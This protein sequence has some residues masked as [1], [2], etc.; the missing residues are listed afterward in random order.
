MPLSFFALVPLCLVLERRRTFLLGWWHGL[1]FWATSMVWILG[2]LTT[3][4]QLAGWLAGISLLLL[5]LWLGIYTALFA[6]IG[7]PLWRSGG[8]RAL[9]G[10]PALWVVLEVARGV[11]FTGFPWNLAAHS[12]LRLPGAL[13]LSAWIGAWGVSFLVLFVNLALARAWVEKR[14]EIGALALLLVATL[15]AA[16]GRWGSGEPE[17]VGEARQRTAVVVQPNTQNQ[18]S[19]DSRRFEIAYARLLELSNGACEPGRLLLWPES[20]AWPL[21]YDRDPRLA[22]DIARLNARGCSVLFNSTS[23]EGSRYFNS[24]LLADEASRIQRYD[25]RHLVPFGEYVPLAGVFTFIKSIARNAG[26]FSPASEL[27]LLDWKGE[28]LGPALCYEVVFPGE[29]AEVVRAGAT[30]LVTATNDAWYG[31]SA[32]PWQHLAAARFR[33]AESRR[34]LLRAAITGVSAVIAPNGALRGQLGV[35][36]AGTLVA[37]VLGESELSPFS[38]APWLVPAVAAMVTLAACLAA[39]RRRLKLL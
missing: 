31:D 4:G 16:G 32:A 10:L 39:R 27:D 29:V 7:A 22:A 13:P 15:L 30:V 5:G 6:W 33:A 25:K 20:A 11:L 35:G 38:R 36:E 19:F 17:G 23:Q 2:T 21:A 26:D 24:L 28:R 1:I 18:V 8:W 3:Y 9:L 37:R 34:F 14:W 12:W